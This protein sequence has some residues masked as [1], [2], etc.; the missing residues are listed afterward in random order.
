[1]IFNKQNKGYQTLSLYP[2]SNWTPDKSFL[3]IP[4]GSALAE[5]IIAN[6][7]N[8]ECVFDDA[9]ALIDV[10]LVEPPVDLEALRGAKHTELSEA[11]HAAIVA[12]FDVA[13]SDGTMG[14]FSMEETDQINL[15]AAVA[16]VERGAASYPYH[17]D[18]A[19][20]KLF[21][22][23]DILR[24]AQA[25][26]AH[27]L[28]HTTYCNHMLAWARRTE[29]AAELDGMTYGAALP[30]DLAANMEEVLASARQV[31]EDLHL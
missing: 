27:K 10:V 8:F 13:L 4:D 5:K 30:A 19:L 26:T 20:C 2:N 12:G 1:M 16:A 18:G 22:A 14:H 29:T 3:V 7:P 23:A 24:V 25:A 9:G 31:Q 21:P 17:A 15:T 6:Y 28:Y 11:S